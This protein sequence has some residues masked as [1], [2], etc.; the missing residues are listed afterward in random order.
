MIG[1]WERIGSPPD[2]QSLTIPFDTFSELFG[3]GEELGLIVVQVEAG[4]DPNVIAEKITS[5]LRK[6]R[7]LKDGKE[8]FS[9]QTPE[10]LAAAFSTIL[11]IVQIVLVGIAAISLLVGGIGIMNTMYTSVLERTREIGILKAVGA[12]NKH[13]LFL[14]LVESGLYGLGGGILGVTIGFSIAKIVEYIF[15]FAVGPAFLSVEFNPSL[16]FGTLLFSFCVGCISGIAPARRA[17]KLNPVDSLR[18]E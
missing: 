18:Y 17:S 2:D 4:N 7:G 5:E 10:Q 9:I 1:L 12:Q 3:T 16:I 11:D 13:I 6:S 15:I 8:D 14:V